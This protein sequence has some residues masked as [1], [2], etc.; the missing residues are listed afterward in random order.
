MTPRMRP[1]QP[2]PFYELPWEQFQELCR[3]LL[4]AQEHIATCDLYGRPGQSQF[5]IDLLARPKSG[6]GIEVAQCKCSKNF[7]SGMVLAVSDEFFKHWASRWSRKSVKRFLLL[8]ACPLDDRDCQDQITVE[9]A[10]SS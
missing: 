8:V 5:G 9:K 10:L 3:D 7:G 4:D 2:P 6:E 1:G